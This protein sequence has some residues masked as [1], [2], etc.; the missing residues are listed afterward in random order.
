M[1]EEKKFGKPTGMISDREATERI[2]G[3][4]FLLFFFAVLASSLLNYLDSIISG[5]SGSFWSRIA[6]YFLEHIWPIWKLIAVII[7][8]FSVVGII[9]NIRKLS[10][11]NIEEDK[12]FNPRPDGSVIEKDGEEIIELKNARWE[13]ILGYTN[14]GNPSDWRMAVI[15]ADAM[16]EEVLRATGYEGESVGDMLK[17]VDKNEFSTI[18]D[19]WEAHKVRNCIAHSGEGFQLNERETKRVIALFEKVFTEFRII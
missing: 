3:L 14:S 4:L 15:E 5:A 16:L 8:A 7:S 1:A 18:D 12:I 10:A 13:K 17:N 2:I 19:A 11:I 6:D 9:Y